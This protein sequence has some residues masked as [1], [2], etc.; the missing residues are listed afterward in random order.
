MLGSSSSGWG[1]VK[2]TSRSDSA[3]GLVR[4]RR[5]ETGTLAVSSFVSGDGG[6]DATDCDRITLVVSGDNDGVLSC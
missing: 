4:L 1:S 2:K 6:D 3:L 5:K